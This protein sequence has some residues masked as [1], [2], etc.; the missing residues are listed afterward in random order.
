MSVRKS[1]GGNR[2]SWNGRMNMGGDST[3]LTLEARVNPQAHV[4]RKARPDKLCRD[5]SLSGKHTRVRDI[6]EQVDKQSPEL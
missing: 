5:Q 2:N 4:K 6:M 3:P 1:L